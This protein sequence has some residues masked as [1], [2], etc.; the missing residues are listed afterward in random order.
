MDLTPNNLSSALDERFHGRYYSSAFIP[1]PAWSTG[2]EYIHNQEW[3][4][5]ENNYENRKKGYIPKANLHP[6]AFSLAMNGIDALHFAPRISLGKVTVFDRS[7][8]ENLRNL[9]RLIE[10]YDSM[11]MAASL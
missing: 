6:L 3:S 7:E 1:S 2:L 10:F 4:I 11:K 5:L 9:R 8:I